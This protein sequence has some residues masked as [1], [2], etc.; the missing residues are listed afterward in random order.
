MCEKNHNINLAK[1]NN[2]L[3]IMSSNGKEIIDT[4]DE[5][6]K[7]FFEE[8]YSS[9]RLVNVFGINNTDNM[10]QIDLHDVKFTYAMH[11]RNW[12]SSCDPFLGRHCQR[13]Y[14]FKENHI[15]RRLAYL[16]IIVLVLSGWNG[17]KN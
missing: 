6:F 7:Y 9:N 1:P 4:L 11:S 14:S 15:P 17:R 8:K 3:S 16:K 2:L 12:N 10:S 13:G 5:V